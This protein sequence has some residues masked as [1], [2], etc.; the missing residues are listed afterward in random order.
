MAESR[1]DSERSQAYVE[2]ASRRSIWP[3]VNRSVRGESGGVPGT[4]YG[5]SAKVLG[6]P[7]T[8]P[9]PSGMTFCRLDAIPGTPEFT[10]ELPETAPEPPGMVFCDPGISPGDPKPIPERVFFGIRNLR[11]APGDWKDRKLAPFSEMAR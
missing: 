1:G 10:L 8:V 6:S 2:Y 4:V 9:V 11:D 5:P 7:E 3:E